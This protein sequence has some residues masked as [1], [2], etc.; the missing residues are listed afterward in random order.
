MVWDEQSDKESTVVMGS[1]S[2]ADLDFGDSDDD[3][4]FELADGSN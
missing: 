1:P 3:I 2:L 4:E